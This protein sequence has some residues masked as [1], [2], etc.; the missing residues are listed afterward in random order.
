MGKKSFVLL[1]FLA[2]SFMVLLNGCGSGSYGNDGAN[3]VGGT[4]E[5]AILTDDINSSTMLSVVKA[6]IDANATNAF[7][8]KSVKIIYKTKDINGKDINASGL[9]VIPVASD[10]YK[11]YL[12]TLGKSFSV[13]L[14]CDN[15]G[16][17]FLNSEAPS[18]AEKSDGLPNN[19]LAVMMTGY[20]GFAVAMPDYVGYGDS[21][22]AVH[23]YILKS[24]AQA[25]LDMI[26]ASI[27]Y[28][29]DNK[30]LFNGQLFISG[31]SEGGYVS[32]VLAKE[33]EEKYSSEF[34]L[35][36]V[37]PMAGPYDIEALGAYD[38]NASMKMVYPAFLAEIAYSYSKAYNNINL[39]D[40]VVKPSVFTTTKLFGGDYDAV[41]IQVALGLAD[42]AKGDYG[43][44]T[45][46]TN[47]L[48]KDSFLNDYQTNA[49][50][51]VRVAFGENSV[52]DWSPKS[53]MN[54]IQCIDDEI[55][56][57]KIETLKTY[58]TF[59]ANGAQDVNIT[60]IP[61]SMIAP[62]STTKPFVHQ[63]CA[64]VAYGAAVK[65]FSD[66]RSGVIK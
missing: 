31:Y 43:F 16:T 20:A 24:S 7:G 36:G 46:Y 32:M 10:A 51:P 12:T 42:P 40:L 66:I 33:I 29:T 5:K 61:S 65:W 17:I 58:Q 18:V 4:L 52:Y 54:L 23:P 35:K 19:S 27:K 63:R 9:L 47:E 13:S 53:K 1:T 56:P 22:G 39:S 57:Y 2:T 15:H 60:P 14:I 34:H 21:K 26:R 41:S 55:I 11:A 50:D 8:Y 44:Y 38:L 6:K 62:A 49:N 30:I 45:H 28:M 48:F 25:S 59:I 3:S 37:A 64:P